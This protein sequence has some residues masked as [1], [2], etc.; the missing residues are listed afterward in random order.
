VGTLPLVATQAK[1]QALVGALGLRIVLVGRARLLDPSQAFLQK[2]LTG[3]FPFE[4]W[5]QI[6][7]SSN[8]GATL[9]LPSI[10]KGP[11]RSSF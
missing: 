10:A 4:S 5:R 6:I 9:V 3:N 8:I 1:E 7:L 2:L 11:K